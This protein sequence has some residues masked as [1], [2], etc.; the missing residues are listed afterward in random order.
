MSLY[1]TV[2]GQRQALLPAIDERRELQPRTEAMLAARL[3]TG[4]PHAGR[5]SR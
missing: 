2:F 1:Q 3:L 4:A 5:A